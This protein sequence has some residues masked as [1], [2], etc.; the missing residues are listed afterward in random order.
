MHTGA[1]AAVSGPTVSGAGGG[2][3]GGDVA[4]AGR[5]AGRGAGAG[6]ASGG[7]RHQPFSC[8][9]GLLATGDAAADSSDGSGG[10][11]G[12]A[13]GSACSR[14][15]GVAARGAGGRA[16]GSNGGHQTPHLQAPTPDVPCLGFSAPS[17]PWQLLLGPWLWQLKFWRR[18][19]W[20][21]HAP[22][23]WCML[24]PSSPWQVA[25]RYGPLQ[26]L[27]AHLLA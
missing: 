10:A 8:S 12:S 22:C 11:G 2:A 24:S 5:G 21:V 15:A 27:V 4:G 3:C 18:P 6:A 23:P 13:G 25:E 17:S 7:G 26:G 16:V 14:D 9:I 20:V 1:A 19:C